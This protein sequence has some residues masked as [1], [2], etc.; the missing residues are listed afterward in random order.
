ML[1]LEVEGEDVPPRPPPLPPPSPCCGTVV[2]QSTAA[3]PVV[4][5][6]CAVLNCCDCE[7][8]TPPSGF[9]GVKL[10]FDCS[11]STSKPLPS[12]TAG[13]TCKNAL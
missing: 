3:A 9:E 7:D 8:V 2:A 5:A 12:V 10:T 6:A 4:V 1:V 13:K 11:S